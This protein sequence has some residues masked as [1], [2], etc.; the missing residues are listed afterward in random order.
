[1]EPL[2]GGRSMLVQ[3]ARTETCALCGH[4]FRRLTNTHLRRHGTTPARYR[5]RFSV[6]PDPLPELRAAPWRAIQQH[7]IVCLICGS[8]FRSLT[9]RHL[10]THGTTPDAYCERFAYDPT[11]P[12]LARTAQR[13]RAV[14][15]IRLWLVPHRRRR[16]RAREGRSSP[17][18]ASF[19]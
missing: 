4:T 9:G 8:A 2:R 5:R 15:L 10:A 3:E 13:R 7:A 6:R 11:Q 12:L 16:R 14:R 18:D 1:M 17:A 19:A